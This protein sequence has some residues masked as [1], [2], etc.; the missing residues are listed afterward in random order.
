[1][2]THVW[3]N[4]R[5]TPHTAVHKFGL[6]MAILLACFV[7]V[8]FRLED[9]DVASLALA[10]ASISPIAWTVSLAAT[11]ASFL[12][13]ARYDA[14]FH[15]WLATGVSPSRAALTGAASIALSQ[16]LG[17]GLFTGTLCRWRMLPD[18]SL[19]KAATITGYVSAA[20]MI[21]LGILTLVA[22]LLS[23]L[24]TSWTVPF[25]ALIATTAI[26]LCFFS[27]RQPAWMP[28]AIPPIPLLIR[29]VAATSIDVAFA[30][31][32]F[33][34]LLPGDIDVSIP[35]VLPVF[36]LGLGAGLMSGTPFGLGPF[37]ICMLTLLPQVPT[38]DLL[39]AI[40]GFRLVFF[41]IPACLAVLVLAWPPKAS[42]QTEANRTGPATSIL[43]A[44]AGFAS[45]SD[46]H[47][48][49]RLAR[50]ICVIARGSQALVV[51]G[52]P[53]CNES[54]NSDDIE[55]LSRCAGICRHLPMI[56]K[57]TKRTAVAVRREGWSVVAVSENAWVNPQDFDLDLPERRQ[58]RRKLRKANR[59]KVIV[60]MAGQLPLD[61]MAGI[62][63]SWSARNGGERGFSMGQ[64]SHGYVA[65]QKVFLAF[66][67]EKPVAFATFHTSAEDWTLDLLRSQEGTPDGAMQALIVVAI[68]Q[69]KLANI[70]R[71]S[72]SAMPLKCSHWPISILSN[73]PGNAG[74]RQFK[75]SFA[76]FTHT[77]YAAARTR[78]A[79][80]LGGLD[81]LLRILYPDPQGA[82]LKRSRES[83]Q[84]E[85]K[86][87]NGDRP[88]SDSPADLWQN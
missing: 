87:L 44:D 60:E 26:G 27:L 69:A 68:Q 47:S 2:Q 42:K 73:R 39:A 76:P 75:L 51:V 62:A 45:V 71:V 83:Q 50:S 3:S 7:A 4:L 54:I 31:L 72:L 16:F 28:F 5:T 14:M 86:A 67:D 20:F 11:A 48:T 13:V 17:F 15:G 10:M 85:A 9:F 70:N 35:F 32:A 21:S 52:D 33:W 64:F 24:I 65:L 25:I 58:L 18:V 38:A 80:F 41:A 88:T 57:C 22:L 63:Q 6:P 55:E 77:L 37:E 1:M 74:L 61:A 23:G 78:P 12:A 8:G 82:E 34:I 81:I 19:P 36:L 49:T 30:A 46:V 53:V 66:Q 79:L 43:S 59:A 56:Y 84:T 29:I 40:L